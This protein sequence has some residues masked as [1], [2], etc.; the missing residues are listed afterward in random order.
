MKKN[1]LKSI[2]MTV[3]LIFGVTGAWADEITATLVHTASSYCGT[4]NSTFTSTVDA[5]NEHI[6]NSKFTGTWAGAAYAEFS[7]AI[8][9]GQTIQSASLAWNGVGSNKNRTTDVMYVNA[10]LTL[11]YEAMAA[12]DAKV[13]LGATKITNVSFPANKTT[14]FNTDVT[15]AVKEFS[16]QG[17]VIFKFTNNAGGGDLVGKGAAEGAPVLTIVTTDA[18]AMTSYTVKFTDGAGNELKDAA[19]YDVLK[20]A[21]A[22][23]SAADMAAFFNAD[24]TMKYIYVSGNQTI[25]AAENAE[26]N[27]I[28][29]IFRE[30]ETWNYTINAV[31]GEGNLLKTLK[32]GTN[33]EAE[34]FDVAYAAYININGTIYKSS[35]QSSDG[36]GY[37]FALDLNAD[38][39]T[40]DITFTASDITGVVYFSE[41]EDINGLTLTS[42]NNTFIR[43]SNGASAYAA[44]GDVAFTTLSNGK[45]KLA[46]VICDATKNAGSVWNFKAGEQNIFEFTAGNV[47]WAEGTSEEF[48]L[49]AAS[50]D[51][52][53][54]KNGG[55][56]QG[57]DLIYIIKTGDAELAAPVAANGKMTFDSQ[58]T[59]NNGSDGDITENKVLTADEFT[60]TVSPKTS[61]TTNNRFWD[62]KGTVELRVYNGTLTVK[63]AAGKTLTKIAFEKG[64]KWTNPTAN[65]GTFDGQ[66]WTGE[67]EE[68]VFTITSQ[69][70][71]KSITVGDNKAPAEPLVDAANIAAFK[72]LEAGTRAKLAVNGAKVTFVSGDYTYIEDETGALLLYQTGLTLTAGK[73]ITGFINGAYTEHKGLPELTAIDETAASEISEAD[74][75]ITAT[76]MT[77][78]EANVVANASKLVKLENVNINADLQT[79]TQGEDEIAFYDKFK[80]MDGFTYPATAKSIVGILNTAGGYNTFCPVGPDYV[81][82][83]T[84]AED[85]E[86]VALTADMFYT[87]DGYGADASKL[88][89]AQVEFYI[90]NGSEIGAGGMVCGTSTVDHLT[91]ADVTGCSKMIIEGT[92][93]MALRVLTNR[94]GEG[95]ALTE[96]NPTIGENGTAELD[97][98]DQEYIHINAI[99]VNWG[100]AAGQITSIKLVKPS[101]ALAIPKEA[102]KNAIANAKLYDAVAKTEESFANLQTAIANGEA[103]LA[104]ADATEESL[105]AAKSAIE[106]AIAGLTLQEGYSNLTKEMFMA[107]ASFDEPG[108]GTAAYGAYSLFENTGLPY[109]DGNVNYLSWADL[110][111][112]DKLIIT[113]VGETKPR[114]CLNRLTPDGQQAETKEDSKML[115]INPNNDVTWSNDAYQTIDGNVYTIDLKKIV[116][117]YTFARLHCIK[118][119]GWGPDVFVTGMYLYSAAEETM[120]VAENIAAAK[121]EGMRDKEIKLNV[122]GAKVTLY[123]GNNMMESFIEDETGA[124]MVDFNISKL[125]GEDGVSLTGYIIGKISKDQRQGG[126]FKFEGTDNTASS[127]ITKETTEIVPAATTIADI[128]AG[129][130]A[131][132]TSKYIRLENVNVKYE[133]TGW[134][135]DISLVDGDQELYVNDAMFVL[136]EDM[137]IVEK[138]NSISGIVI[139]GYNGLEFVPYGTFDAVEK[140]IEFTEVAN[141]AALKDIA[142]D[143]DV[144]LAL[145]NTQIKVLEGGRWDKA[146]YIE[147][148][149]AGIQINDNE[150]TIFTEFGQTFNGYIYLKYKDEYGVKNL[151]TAGYTKNSEYT[152]E[153]KEVV[154]KEVAWADATSANYNQQLIKVNNVELA[155][156]TITEGEG[157]DAYSYNVLYL[158]SGDKDMNMSDMFNK[159]YDENGG[160]LEPGMYNITG[161]I[162]EGPVYDENYE[163][164]GYADYFIPTGETAFEAVVVEPVAD[165]RKWDFRAWSEETVA[166]MAADAASVVP[167]EGEDGTLVYPTVT[168]WRSY[169]K[170]GGPTE[171]DPDREG[172]AYWYGTEINGAEELVANGTVIAETKGLLFNK[173]AAGALAVG[174]NYPSTSLGTYEGPSYLWIG[175]RNNSFTIPTVKSGSKVYIGIESHKNTDARGVKLTIDGVELGQAVPKTFQEFVFTVPGETTDGTASDIVVTNTNGCHIY[176]IYVDAT[177]EIDGINDV[178]ANVD[179]VNNAVYT[180]NGVK[181]RNAGESLEGLAKG[182]YIIGGKKVVVK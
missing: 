168:P 42:N 115:D 66:T 10:G 174:I 25:T 162:M 131:D 139:Y 9:E 78:A 176:Y 61:G 96:K 152:V 157:E 126:I 15:D 169:E 76:V 32:Q 59:S 6:N 35:K 181:V 172:N 91:Y 41:A 125:F 7:I 129:Q 135:A 50:T 101:D 133:S 17:Y 33:F 79:I 36:K 147:D 69:C 54:V 121:E 110:T 28:T 74:A 160:S 148:E 58:P 72:A 150:G 142:N 89:P 178:K 132:V 164:A 39:V 77:V 23:A 67:A 62:N 151:E 118:K 93:G 85:E 86:I 109:G 182:M 4:S 144:K 53:L 165:L 21:E 153:V 22:T 117:D 103:A 154:A 56:N 163:V 16:S 177:G 179:F 75:E 2:L 161:I 127:E 158:K 146:V 120:P 95:G 99:K 104:A 48:E 68:V 90:G 141:I 113:T 87:W 45:Y 105:A 71:I 11:D 51:I 13:D 30:A 63:A 20:G 38:N 83:D 1:L 31:D 57:V 84:P 149:T 80:V 92:P 34:K 60:V 136:P 166:N 65:V 170:V 29:L 14:A 114:L 94:Q 81:V 82:A 47:N 173:M 19:T 73:A 143:T 5:E 18:S 111:A 100:S 49:N 43:S 123:G 116:E 159:A 98:T 124:L 180:I 171:A 106:E 167:T 156:K 155:V 138:F 12:G 64:S 128:N 3:A 122:T 97:L 46:T 137:S 119:Q 108:E 27:V 37:Y 130:V 145:N 70:Q 88:S 112:Y 26:S 175:G 55:M 44:D 40:K 107:Y 134:S 52:I 24:K 102:L 140:Q 8:P